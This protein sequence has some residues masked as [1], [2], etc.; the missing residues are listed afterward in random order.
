MTPSILQLKY[1][2][3]EDKKTMPC[4][5]FPSATTLFNILCDEKC[6]RIQN[7]CSKLSDILVDPNK[8]VVALWILDFTHS[9]KVL[10][11]Y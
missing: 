9:G 10:M 2:S 8:A 6:R 3:L 11:S 4:F 5:S 7:V 1:C